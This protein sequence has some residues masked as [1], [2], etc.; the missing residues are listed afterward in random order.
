MRLFPR[1]RRGTWLLAGAVWLAGCSRSSSD[2]QV[3]VFK[4]PDG[5]QFNYSLFV[6]HNYRLD[7]PAP[8]FM[9]LHGSAQAGTDGVKPTE[10][11]IG[12]AVRAR[13]ADF[14]FFVIFPQASDRVPATFGS[15][16]PGQPDGDRALAILDLVQKDF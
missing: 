2:F 4:A 10:V 6:P 7:S 5:T 3:R 15:W 9:F 16:L 1:S 12:P 13:A 11:G 8:A 14:P